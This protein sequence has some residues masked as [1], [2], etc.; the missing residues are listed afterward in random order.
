MCSNWRV[1]A[2]VVV[3]ILTVYRVAWPSEDEPHPIWWSPSLGLESLDKIDERLARKFWPDQSEGIQVV[4]GE[5]PGD[6]KAFID[7]CVS[8]DK[9][10]KEGYYAQYNHSEQV[11]IFQ[12]S[13]CD[14]FEMLRDAKP[15]KESHV[16]KII[17]D[18]TFLNY[19]PAIVDPSPSCDYLCRQYA[20]NERRIPWYDFEVAHFLSV[21]V[22]NDYRMKVTTDTEILILEG[23]ARAD[24]NG[25][26]LED[27]LL[28]VT[29]GPIGGTWGT[30][31]LYLLS[32]ETP[33]SVLWAL[34]ADKHLCPRY[35]CENYY[36]Y[37]P[38]LRGSD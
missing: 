30:T 15:A 6:A 27:L 11:L 29:A 10:R 4:K 16:N 14:A 26:G 36:T 18:K 22:E 3:V 32:R 5:G 37:P 21:D 19:L 24:F 8:Y 35:H 31:R 9:L 25:D 2:V 1:V 12:S 20:A 7:S 34:A 38:A 17:F 33:H 28:R 13:Y 23:L